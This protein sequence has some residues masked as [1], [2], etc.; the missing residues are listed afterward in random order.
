M[1]NK[2]MSNK[3]MWFEISDFN[4][5][6]SAKRNLNWLPRTEIASSSLQTSKGKLKQAA[7][8]CISFQGVIY[9]IEEKSAIIIHPIHPIHPIH[10][11]S[12]WYN[13]KGSIP[14][15]AKKNG[16]PQHMIPSYSFKYT[17]FLLR[18]PFWIEGSSPPWLSCEFYGNAMHWEISR[19]W[20]C[21]DSR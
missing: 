5:V 1:S 6:I 18:L 7:A 15:R 17:F 3:H 4:N 8:K 16:R 9:Q 11:R 2:R 14:V 13:R 20:I 10:S 19:G 12:F 21:I